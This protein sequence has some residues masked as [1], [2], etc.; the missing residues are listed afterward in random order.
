MAK[1]KIK[2]NVPTRYFTQKN[3][4]KLEGALFGGG[5]LGMAAFIL[6]YLLVYWYYSM[7]GLYLGGSCI[8]AYIAIT[9]KKV[10]DDG[11]DA[12]VKEFIEK[13]KLAP[14]AKYSLSLYDAGRGYVK[15]CKDR[16]LRS[17]L[18]C[19]SEFEFG[20]E[21][22]D[23]TLTEIDFC[24][25]GDG[26][27]KVTKKQYSLPIGMP[28]TVE[29]FTVETAE[30]KKNMQYLVLAPEDGAPIKLPIDTTS[31]DSDEIISKIKG[32]R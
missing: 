31:C 5:V 13:N 22:F 17:S 10:K 6:F 21:S 28:Y 16:K 20:R 14:T 11:Y 9:S 4:D 8:I 1:N 29:D 19:I 12:H 23:L 18:Y 7:I 26:A 27:P 30:G 32:R 24:E 2:Q 3:R 15:L 25:T